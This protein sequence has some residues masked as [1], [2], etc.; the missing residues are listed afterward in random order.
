MPGETVNATE[1]FVLRFCR[2]SF[3]SLW[4]YS[5]PRGKG[6]K[7]LCDILV[8]CEPDIIIVSVKAIGLG[9]SGNPAVDWQ[10][11]RRRAI[12][13]SAD[14]IYGAER[15]LENAPSVI[16]KDGS[17]GLPLPAKSVR[18]VH[19]VA[20]ALGSQGKAPLVFGD[21]GRGFV[22]VF[23][24]KSLAIIMGELDTV[25]DF[26]A[27]LASKEDLYKS[28][29]ET[30]FAGSEEDLF[31][32]YLHRG[33]KFPDDADVLV[34]TDGIWE[35]LENKEQYRARKLA[36]K[37]SYAWDR[38]ID[39]IADDVLKGTLEFGP[40]LNDSERGLRVMAREN[41]FARRILGK[42][43]MEF[44][45]LASAN[46]VRSRM[47]VSLSDV[48]YVFLAMPHGE[49]RKF[50]VAELGCR[51]FIARGQNQKST[52]V[53][54]L[55]TEQYVKGKGFS[56]DMLYLYKPQWTDEDEK[57][58]VGMQNDLKFFTAPQYS[59]AHEDEY[60]AGT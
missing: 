48:A 7:E 26:V 14:Q 45:D 23:D 52:T 47:I 30:H 13:A 41:R 51:C 40:A 39:K 58:L 8:V 46:K 38:I 55:A 17:P 9:E 42:A 33:R 21:F 57:H 24:E 15:W 29:V 5:N 44:M 49:D 59:S 2:R 6:G 16:R 50:R 22:H 12:E 36:D 18:R 19:R 53:V 31:A 1:E 35:E 54:G 11:W 37:L 25:S 34:V 27:Y 56:F 10:R 20:V 60:P 4:S 3:L 28:G 43:F 32:F